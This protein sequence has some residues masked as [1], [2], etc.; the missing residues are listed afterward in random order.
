MHWLLTVF[1]IVSMVECNFHRMN[2]I[3]IEISIQRCIKEVA[4]KALSIFY[5]IITSITI[6][7]E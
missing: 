2:V 6:F 7:T 1:N 3:G 4:T 5:E